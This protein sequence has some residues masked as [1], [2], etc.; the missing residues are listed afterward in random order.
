MDEKKQNNGEPV[1]SNPPALP[2]FK[3]KSYGIE[4]GSLHG[5][6]ALTNEFVTSDPDQ[7]LIDKVK[8]MSAPEMRK[9]LRVKGNEEGL[10]RAYM[11]KGIRR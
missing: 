11:N 8:S 3:K 7:E 10:N 6:R 9:W 5:G 2:V 1:A 4:P